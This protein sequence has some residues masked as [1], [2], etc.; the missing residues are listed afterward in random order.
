M[1]HSPHPDVEAAPS[2]E[3]VLP[4]TPERRSC[5]LATGLI[6]W[7]PNGLSIARLLLGL[8]FPWL[9]ESW[10]L[11]VIVVAGLSDLLDGAASRMLHV[12]PCVG[13]V[14]DPVADKVFA[15]GVVVTFL[16][17]GLLT[18]WELILVGLRDLL[19]T[20]AVFA[21]LARRDWPAFR[22]L[23]PTL[24]GKATTAAQF[25]F[26]TALLVAPEVRGWTLA[27]TAAL[28]ALAAGHYFWLYVSRHGESA[29]S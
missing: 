10:R 17:D 16:V 14:L 18:L 5:N 2:G 9:P 20:V 8:G 24:L 21:G 7:I 29:S 3:S 26:F 22:R 15:A 1:T 6:S 11:P 28:S 27:A 19:V 23:A 12:S 4:S 13:R 25:A